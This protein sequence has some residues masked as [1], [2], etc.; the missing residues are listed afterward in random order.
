[1]FNIEVLVV[2]GELLGYSRL[3]G[4]DI[5]RRLGGMWVYV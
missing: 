1:M 5:I 2:D 4:V 3:L